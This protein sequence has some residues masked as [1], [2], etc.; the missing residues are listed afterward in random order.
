MK[1]LRC[2]LGKHRFVHERASQYND[3]DRSVDVH[4][5]KYCQDCGLKLDKGIY[6][7]DN[8][9]KTP[10]DGWEYVWDI[11]TKERARFGKYI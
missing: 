7:Y 5:S 6:H 10:K 3:V 8:M 1:K 4:Y 11:D 2:L 9:I